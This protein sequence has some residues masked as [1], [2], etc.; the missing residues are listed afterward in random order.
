M[1]DCISSRSVLVRPGLIGQ[2]RGGGVLGVSNLPKCTSIKQRNIHFLNERDKA[3][4]ENF[5]I[6]RLPFNVTIF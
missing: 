2:G 6:K 5:L 3:R 1:R 4:G